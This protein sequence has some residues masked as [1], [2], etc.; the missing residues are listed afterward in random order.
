MRML[1]WFGSS[2]LAAAGSVSVADR[3]SD[4]CVELGSEREPERAPLGFRRDDA[5]PDPVPDDVN[6]HV[7]P[8]DETSYRVSSA[9]IA[10]GSPEVSSGSP[11]GID[12]ERS[13]DHRDSLSGERTPG[14]ALQSATIELLGDLDVRRALPGE[15]ADDLDCLLGRFPREP[16]PRREDL[17]DFARSPEQPDLRRA[18][19]HLDRRQY[20]VLD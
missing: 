19:G 13:P 16:R 10:F 17:G 9:M 20:D 14:R 7:V 8:S 3:F 18:L 2:A 15:L 12:A 11:A 6:R 1:C 5:G 4:P